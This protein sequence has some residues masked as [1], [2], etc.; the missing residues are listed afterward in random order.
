MIFLSFGHYAMNIYR[1]TRKDL[2]RWRKYQ[3]WVAMLQNNFILIAISAS[4][5]DSTKEEIQVLR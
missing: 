4:I 2:V 1:F 5:M 3:I